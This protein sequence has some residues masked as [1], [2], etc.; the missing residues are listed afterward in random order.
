[1]RLLVEAH[2]ARLAALA[3][4]ITGSADAASDVAEETFLRALNATI[5]NESGTV[6]GFL[7]TIAYRLA[8]KEAKRDRRNVE[9]DG[10]NLVRDSENALERILR[11][12]RDCAVA[13]V[14][15][16]LDEAH[17]SVLALRFYGGFSYEE[18]AVEVGAPLGTVKSRIFYAVKYCRE[19]LK[20]RGVF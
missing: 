17:R 20:Q 3:L 19:T 14:I 12:E 4:F 9:L 8:L 15:A 10:L 11:D 13:E 6:R 1:L 5:K 2:Q 7:G 16:A 18:I